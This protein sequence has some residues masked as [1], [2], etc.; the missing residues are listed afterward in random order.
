MWVTHGPGDGFFIRSHC[1]GRL[2][3]V[4]LGALLHCF[5]AKGPS[6]ILKEPLKSSTLQILNDPVVSCGWKTTLGVNEQNLSG[7]FCETGS[8]RKP[9]DC[10]KQR[11][12]AAGAWSEL[13]FDPEWLVSVGNWEMLT[14]FLFQ[15]E[16][17]PHLFPPHPRALTPPFGSG[18]RNPLPSPCTFVLGE[19]NF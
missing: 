19:Y 3:R 13:A 6:L 14:F 16:Q 1:W 10:G 9:P 4:R 7:V 11:G 2:P 5:Y 12:E 8:S 18:F 17:P 15:P